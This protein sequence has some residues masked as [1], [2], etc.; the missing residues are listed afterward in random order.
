[1]C[2]GVRGGRAVA[3][4]LWLA[5]PRWRAYAEDGLSSRPSDA[6]PCSLRTICRRW[7]RLGVGVGVGVGL[8]LGQRFGFGFGAVRC[9][10]VRRRGAPPAAAACLPRRSPC[11][12][13][14]AWPGRRSAAARRAPRERCCRPC[15]QPPRGGGPPGHAEV[16][17]RWGRGG[18]EMAEARASR[19]EG[20]RRAC[21]ARQVG[22]VAGAARASRISRPHD[23]PGEICE[24]ALGQRRRRRRRRRRRQRSAHGPPHERRRRAGTPRFRVAAARWRRWFAL[25]WFGGVRP[26]G[27]AADARGRCGQDGR[28]LGPSQRRLRRFRRDGEGDTKHS[29]RRFR[30][31]LGFALGEDLDCRAARRLCQH[32]VRLRVGVRSRSCQQRQTGLVLLQEHRLMWVPQYGGRRATLV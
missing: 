5:S 25:G 3:M 11:A 28:R 24:A 23:R 16:A 15:A 9:G 8:R 14:R 12:V 32:F 6:A 4:P 30:W 13:D 18:V 22:R 1:M 19:G 20:G 26:G 7:L 31:T 10:V 17:Q 27:A 29:R 2:D 21:L